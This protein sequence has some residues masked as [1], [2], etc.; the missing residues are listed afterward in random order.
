MKKLC[1]FISLFLIITNCT[2]NKVNKSHG[3]KNL[4]KKSKKL[5]VKQTN[6]N[7]IFNILGPPSTKGQLDPNTW[8]YIERKITNSTILKIG[9]EKLDENNLLVLKIDNKGILNEMKFYNKDNMN[10][11]KF[12]ENITEN[13]FEKDG[14]LNTL[15]TSVRQKINDPIRNRL[16]KNKK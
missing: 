11:L 9:K 15:L 10:K 4:E 5:I 13:K 3:I 12:N 7:D 2:V 16:K 1:L 6:K 14:F 8:I